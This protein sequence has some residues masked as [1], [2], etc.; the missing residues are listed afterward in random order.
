MNVKKSH[1]SFS[2]A[3]KSAY[4]TFSSGEYEQQLQSRIER[5]M[6]KKN[7]QQDKWIPSEKWNTHTQDELVEMQRK[8][9]Y[10]FHLLKLISVSVIN[11][12]R[13][14]LT[15]SQPNAFSSYVAFTRLRV[16]FGAKGQKPDWLVCVIYA[17]KNP[18][19]V[20]FRTFS[21]REN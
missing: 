11:F 9:K 21:L 20:Q 14:S 7:R 6:K 3:E 2:G 1:Q 17:S 16:S 15:T 13:R 12:S 18:V 8:R 4:H 10:I 19:D 5:R